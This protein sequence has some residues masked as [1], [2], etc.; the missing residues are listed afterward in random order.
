MAGPGHHPRRPAAARRAPNARSRPHLLAVGAAFV[1]REDA[2]HRDAMVVSSQSRAPA[3][4]NPRQAA[5]MDTPA[6]VGRVAANRPARMTARSAPPSRRLEAGGALPA[7]VPRLAPRC[8]LRGSTPAAIE[9]PGIKGLRRTIRC[10]GSDRPDAPA[11]IALRQAAS[12]RPVVGETIAGPR[13]GGPTGDRA[14]AVH[15][16]SAGGDSFPPRTTSRSGGSL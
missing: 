3:R 2:S 1:E 13:H 15:R 16:A 12:V 11:V 4:S 8:L 7:S 9:H 5:R 6:R 14:A 10:P